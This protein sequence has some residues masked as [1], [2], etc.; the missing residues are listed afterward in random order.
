MET[1]APFSAEAWSYAGQM[2]L[3][4][5][6]MVFVVLAILWMM[7]AVFKLIF[8]GSSPKEK[9]SRKAN[10]APKT[11]ITDKDKT[12]VK[13]APKAQAQAVPIINV[14]VDTAEDDALIAAI[15][16]AAVAAYMAEQGVSEDGFRVVSFK[17]TSK[18]AW[19]A[20]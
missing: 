10:T 20:K 17:R 12:E 19:N 6:G 2:T 8:A 16:T 5:M 7:L 14:P 1:F 3:L 11:D 13:E 9:P 15:I 18:R 4:G